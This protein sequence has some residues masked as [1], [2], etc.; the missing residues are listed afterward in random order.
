MVSSRDFVRV[1][2]G[3]GSSF[4]DADRIVVGTGSS[5]ETVWSSVLK[6][7]GTSSQESSIQLKEALESRGMNP[8]NVSSI[9]FELD[10]SESTDLSELFANM[11]GLEVIQEF[12]VS[13]VTSFFE[14]FFMAQSLT[15]APLRGLRVSV[16]LSDTSLTPENADEMMRLLGTPQPGAMISLPD[17]AAGC[18]PMIAEDKG[19]LVNGPPSTI[20]NLTTVGDNEVMKPSWA[21]HVDYYIIGGGG[22][23]ASG[24]FLSGV[25]NGGS[26]GNTLS[27]TTD[28]EEFSISEGFPVADVFNFPVGE[29]GSPGTSTGNGS[30]SQGARSAA[31]LLVQPSGSR[32]GVQATGGSGG[33]GTGG[34]SGGG[35]P[36][37]T[38]FSQAFP[39]TPTAGSKVDGRTPGGGGGG[40]DTG[41]LIGGGGNPG[42]VGGQGRVWV[43][44]R[45]G[46]N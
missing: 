42:R 33:S 5:V 17:S 25:G 1:V 43:R 8:E 11:S 20:Y 46:A 35:I 10:V 2:L 31:F 14:S 23:G 22:G 41:G 36:A 15:N 34:S 37:K 19:W 26:A 24:G 45:G 16:N 39:A 3:T 30:G 18:N 44:I 27:G 29:G 6:L 32:W 7:T 21:T 9:P 12:D 4:A 40:G 28:L 38:I 13:H